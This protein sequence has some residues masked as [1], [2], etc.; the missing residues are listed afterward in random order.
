MEQNQE[1]RNKPTHTHRQLIYDKE[2][3]SNKDEKKV[4]SIN[5]TGE[6]EQ[7]PLKSDH[8][9]MPYIKVNSKWIKGLN[10]SPET[11][12]YIQENINA[13]LLD[14]GLNDA[15]VDLTPMTRKQKPK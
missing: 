12:K 10:V 1:P 5:G 4:S 8:Y 13:K 14:I 11:T 6:I 7:P 9:V 2:P 3:R 15:F